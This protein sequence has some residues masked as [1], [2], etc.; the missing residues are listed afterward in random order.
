MAT[1][2]TVLDQD[3]PSRFGHTAVT[4]KNLV[5]FFGGSK[6]DGVL[7]TDESALLV[8]N[9]QNYEWLKLG[10]ADAPFRKYHSAVSSNDKLFIFGLFI[11]FS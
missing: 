1:K 6:K 5:Y 2:Q 9:L 10:T 8:F 3:V 11:S 7:V 4:R